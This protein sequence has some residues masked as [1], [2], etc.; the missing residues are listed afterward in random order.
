M[1]KM[2]GIFNKL[3]EDLGVVLTKDVILITT[4]NDEILV[5]L[6]LILEGEQRSCGGPFVHH[7]DF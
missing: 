4:E 6:G 3:E 1:K 7:I 5:S 2:Y